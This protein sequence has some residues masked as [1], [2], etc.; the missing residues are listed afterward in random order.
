MP[1]IYIKR[2]EDTA[3]VTNIGVRG[4]PAGDYKTLV[5]VDGVPVQPGIF[6]GN[7]RYY[8]PRVQS[9]GGAEV[10]KGASSLRFGPNNIGGVINFLTRTPDDGVAFLGRLGSWNT[11]EGFIEA[12]GRSPSGDSRL[13]VIATRASSDGWNDKGWDMSDVMVK[14]GAN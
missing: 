4:L 5:L 10:L 9:I 7:S 3:V 12:G 11:R 1:G 2:E 14:A 8:N 6:V 13:G